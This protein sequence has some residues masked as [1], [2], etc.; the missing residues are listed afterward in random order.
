MKRILSI[1]LT[2][3]LIVMSFSAVVSAA[4]VDDVIAALEEANVPEAYVEQARSYFAENPLTEEDAAAIIGYIEAAAA[5]AD[6]K[7]KISELSGADRSAIL[8]EISKAA[9]VIDLTVSYDDGD[10]N[11]RDASGNLVFSESG[12]GAVKQTGFD[13]SIILF[14]LAGIVLAGSA[15]IVSKKKLASD[16]A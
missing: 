2:T 10:I 9:N 4:P 16:N 15:A 5:I 12:A 6:G 7:T 14:G 1:A 13:Y 11:V 3:L 8:A